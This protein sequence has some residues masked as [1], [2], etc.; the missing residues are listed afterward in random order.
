MS[1]APDLSPSL[2]GHG[3]TG[4]PAA[5]PTQNSDAARD[6]DVALPGTQGQVGVQSSGGVRASSQV[7]TLRLHGKGGRRPDWNA[8]RLWASF[9]DL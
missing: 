5:T 4:D 6:R 9:L 3:P 2:P 7:C 8:V 1:Q